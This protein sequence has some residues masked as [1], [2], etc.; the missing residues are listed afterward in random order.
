MKICFTAEDK[1]LNSPI[2]PRFGR[3][4]FLLFVDSEDEK[5]IKKINN[6]KIAT[7]RGAG[8]ATAQKIADENAQV[9][10]TGNIGPNAFTA[11]QSANIE[12]ITNVSNLTVKQALRKFKTNEFKKTPKPSV[13]GHFGQGKKFNQNRNRNRQGQA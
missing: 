3:C 7:W 1:I 9:V 6:T 11:L 12:I 10:I 8:I 4:K 5:I 2:D 13:L